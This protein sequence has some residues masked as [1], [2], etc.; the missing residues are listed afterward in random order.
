[1]VHLRAETGSVEAALEARGHVPLP[2]VHPPARPPRRPRPL[3]DG[4]RAGEGSVAAPT[5]AFTSRPSCS[6]R[7][8]RRGSASRRSSSTSGRARS[9]RSR[10]RRSRPPPG[11]EPYSIP[12]RGADAIAAARTSG[13]RVVAVAP[14]W[15]GRWRRPPA[16]RARCARARPRPRSWC[17]PG[18]RFRITDA[19]V[20]NFHL[21]R[22]SL[23]LLVRPSRAR[24]R[25]GRVRG[26]GPARLPLLQLRRR[27]AAGVKGAGAA[28]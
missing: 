27:D 6:T 3:P 24:A 19:L 26:S 12:A 23:L 10:R 25:P 11:A 5:R 7:C 17:G 4:L 14:P 21:P 8:A 9:A 15:C 2:P 28:A 20:T 22:S 16:R 18:F 13:G 1:V